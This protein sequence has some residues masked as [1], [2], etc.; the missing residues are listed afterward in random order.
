MDIKTLCSLVVKDF[1]E[2]K[3]RELSIKLGLDERDIE[4]LLDRELRELSLKIINK[5]EANFR[6][7]TFN[8]QNFEKIYKDSLNETLK[9]VLDNIPE[10][11]KKENFIINKFLEFLEKGDIRAILYYILIKR[12]QEKK[13]INT[14]KEVV[15][16]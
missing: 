2:E 14:T 7:E 16:R 10:N 8:K 5:I 13:E 6:L 1:I 3:T 4:N 9:K 11:L 15:T 12:L